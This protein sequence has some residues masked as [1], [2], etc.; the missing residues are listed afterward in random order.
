MAR[1]RMG[2]EDRR[3]RTVGVR[4]TETEAEPR[5]LNRIGVNFNHMARAIN[6]GAVS[7]LAGTRCCGSSVAIVPSTGPPWNAVAT[8][9]MGVALRP[10]NR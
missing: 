2:E 9:A 10:L 4:V 6:S 8:T 3:T 7:S 1:P 5:E